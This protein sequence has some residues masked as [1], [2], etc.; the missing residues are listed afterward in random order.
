MMPRP[1]TA[2]QAA[3]ARPRSGPEKTLVMMERVDGMINAPPIPI[4]ALVAMSMLA[5]PE[6]AAPSDPSPNRSRPTVNARLRPKRSPRAPI[7][8]SRPAKTRM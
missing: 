6:N 3:I 4:A 8:N 2:A 5:D 7:V 1:E